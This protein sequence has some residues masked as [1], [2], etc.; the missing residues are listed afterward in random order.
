MRE[1]VFATFLAEIKNAFVDD[2]NDP[3]LIELLYRGV[4]QPLGIPLCKVQ[5]GTASKIVNRLPNGR[6]LRVLKGHSQDAEVKE[7]IG[8]FFEQNVINHSF[9]PS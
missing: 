4:A 5:K 8:Q 3:D 6:P 1:L 2:I 7:S 9:N